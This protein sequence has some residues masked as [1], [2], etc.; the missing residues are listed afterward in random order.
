[1]KKTILLPV[2]LSILWGCSGFSTAYKQGGRA[3]INRDWDAAILHYEQAALENP[4]EPVYRLALMRARASASLSYLQKARNLAAQEK[5]DEALEVYAKALQY[6][7]QNRLAAREALALTEEKPPEKTE[8][9]SLLEPPVRLQ[10][11]E[12]KIRLKFSE[13]SLR[14]V[15]QALS[16]HSGV[17]VL[18][19]EQFRDVPVT[20]DLTD[21]T[22]EDAV[23]QLCLATR[24]HFRIIDRKTV[25]IYPDQPMKRLQYEMNVVKTFFL[26]NI[27]AQEAQTGLAM[28]VRSQYKAPIITVDKN[29]NALTIRDTPA[30]VALA[31]RLI[32]LWDKP[33]GEVIIDLEIMEVSRIKLKK[34]GLDLSQNILGLRYGG[35][36]TGGED[37]GWFDL[38]TI[39]LARTGN[40]QISLPSAF[41]QFLETEGDTKI[42]A[43][44]R[45]RGLDSQDIKYLVGQKIPIPQTTFTPFAAGGVSQQ[46]ITSYTYQDVGIDVKIKPRIHLEKDISLEIEIKITSIGDTGFAGIPIITTREVKNIIRL[47]DGETNLLAGLLRDEERRSLKGIALLKDVPLL[48]TL[49]SNT[50]RQIEQTDVILTIT[51]YIIRAIPM[52]EEDERPVWVDTEGLSRSAASTPFLPMDEMAA[53]VRMPVAPVSGRPG[54]EDPENEETGSHVLFLNPPNFELPQGREFRISLDMRTNRDIAT[55]S[56]NLSFNPQIIRL[57]DIQE[58]GL[59]RQIGPSVPFLKNIDNTGGGATIGISSPTPGKGFKGVGLLAVLV[60]ESVGPGESH[61]TI[62]GITANTPAGA[63]VVFSKNESRVSVR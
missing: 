53:A 15:F 63:A 48:G 3:E 26:S 9:P 12:E 4:R 60:F 62:S 37:S 30:A 57:K 1:M 13:A 23:I 7:P 35:Q 28:M 45:L 47:K 11:P 25:I 49:F 46:P 38:N 50:D 33:Q 22:V 27:N 17:N 41:L 6:D 56:L 39:D 14:S 59:I 18:Y 19:D 61:V 10:T 24:N 43:Q 40:Y 8:R 54:G 20:I 2:I 31:E 42:I 58:G 29:L 34:L 5:I 52:T 36:E 21:L 16:R 51:P 44:P 55:M 32:R